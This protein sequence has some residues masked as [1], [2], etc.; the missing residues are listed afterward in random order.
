MAQQMNNSAGSRRDFLMLL[1]LG[2]LAGMFATVATAAFRFLRPVRTQTR[3]EWIDIGRI[4]ELGGTRPIARK[5]TREYV[6]GW[7]KSREHNI[8]YILPASNN[9][10]VSAICPHEGCEVAWSDQLNIF[11]CPCHD[12]NFTAEGTRLEGPA[13]RG[14]D[15]L[16]S[17][18]ENGVL[19]I[20]NTYYPSDDERINRG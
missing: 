18:V 17:R 5:V 6:A 12:S 15:L 7:I 3:A 16:P 13:P 10:V 19:Q 14:L 4:D 1:P 9:N 11:E 20:Q 2:I 8:V